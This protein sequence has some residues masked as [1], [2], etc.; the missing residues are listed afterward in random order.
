MGFRRS[1]SSAN[2][3]HWWYGL[4]V[5][6]TCH[7]TVRVVDVSPGLDVCPTCIEKGGTWVHLRQCLVCG[8]TG[9]CD[10]SPNQHAS[11]HY[12]AAGHETVRSLEEG[13]AWSWCF[14]CE[15]TLRK[16]DDGI[17]DEVDTFFE[18]GLWYAHGRA[19]E[20]GPVAV[21]PDETTP[22]GFPIGEWATTYRARRRDGELDPNQIAALEAVP[23]WSW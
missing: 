8:L 20:I 7:H 13:E 16:A 6:A 1:K 10:S 14:A 12:L 19:D 21:A 17:W 2:R 5:I 11:R 4:D 23:G 22:D 3:R 15:V 9:C 18:A